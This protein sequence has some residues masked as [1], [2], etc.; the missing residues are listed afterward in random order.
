MHVDIIARANDLKIRSL[1]FLQRR[2]REILSSRR[3]GFYLAVTREG[4]LQASDN[5]ELV[6]S[7]EQRVTVADITRLHLLEKDDVST[8]QRALRVEALPEAWRQVFR[9]QLARYAD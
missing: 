2:L 5:L 9:E 3:T 7:D 4:K 6:H 8:L 1:V